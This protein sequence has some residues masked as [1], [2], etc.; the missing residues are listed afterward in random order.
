MTETAGVV[1]YGGYEAMRR[2]FVTRL[3]V[4]PKKHQQRFRSTAP[5]A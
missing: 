2:A 5:S 3:G 4:S 1:G